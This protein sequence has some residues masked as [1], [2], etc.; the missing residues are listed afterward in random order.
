M[1]A[2][3]DLAAG[4]LERRG[5]IDA[6]VRRRGYDPRSRGVRAIIG[7][8]TRFLESRAGRALGAAARAGSLRREVPFLLRVTGGGSSAYVVGAADAVIAGDRGVTVIDFKYALARPESRRRYELQLLA[9]ALAAR[10][11]YPGRPISARLQFLRGPCASIDVTPRPEAL[12]RFERD[13]P[14][15]AL[16]AS[17]GEGHRATPAQLG[18]DEARC[19]AEGCGFVGR[20]FRER[21]GALARPEPRAASGA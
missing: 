9:Y 6:A 13:A 5:Q 14:R 1:L 4:P 8:V 10:R 2:E 17:A 3:V 15:L 16:Q 7:D 11:A 20:C 18:R 12:R 21:D 19:R